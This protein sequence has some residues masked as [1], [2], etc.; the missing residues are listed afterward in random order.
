MFSARTRAA[1]V[2]GGM[3]GAPFR[4]SHAFAVR[5]CVVACGPFF[6][7]GALFLGRACFFVAGRAF[8]WPGVRFLGR[9]CFFWPGGL[10]YGRARFFRAGRAFLGPGARFL[11]PGAVV[12]ARARFFCG[13]GVLLGLR[14][15]G[16]A[17][18][19][20]AINLDTGVQS[21]FKHTTMTN[22]DIPGMMPRDRKTHV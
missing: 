21:S 11:G 17:S 14:S 6:W 1:N 4:L 10:F 8:F 19:Q 20:I 15:T 3:G 7:R 18:P 12:L 5:A 2:S 9:A 13:G 22:V 16:S